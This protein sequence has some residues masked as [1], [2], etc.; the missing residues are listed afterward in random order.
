MAVAD[1]GAEP[2]DRIGEKAAAAFALGARE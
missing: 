2:P 1:D